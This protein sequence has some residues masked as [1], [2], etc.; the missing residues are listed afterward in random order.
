M[1]ASNSFLLGA[2]ALALVGCAAQAPSQRPPAVFPELADPQPVVVVAELEAGES[3]PPFPPPACQ[4]AVPGSQCVAVM[5][6]PPP[7]WV[8]AKVDQSVYAQAALPPQLYAATTSHYGRSTIKPGA[9]LVFLRTDGRQF[10]V[11]RYGYVEL[12]SKPDGS[13]HLP[14]WSTQP[15]PWLPCAALELREEIARGDLEGKVPMQ[16]SD[17]Q[18][19]L[20]RPELFHTSAEGVLPRY[21]I[22]VRKLAAYLRQNPPPVN[23][24]ECG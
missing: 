3:L 1:N 6:D 20:R 2:A 12:V 17:Y 5:M 9:R 11:Q 19:A 24:V 22:D 8:R 16:S 23:R 4:S 10:I 13:L 21:A 7:F 15:V 18:P 14:V